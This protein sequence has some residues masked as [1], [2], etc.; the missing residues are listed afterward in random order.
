MVLLNSCMLICVVLN[1]Y[2]LISLG[3]L[4]LTDNW[5]ASISYNKQGYF[6]HFEAYLQTLCR[7]YTCVYK[8]CVHVVNS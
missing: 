7:V 4:I 5:I 8:V 6:E 2:A 1:I 3:F